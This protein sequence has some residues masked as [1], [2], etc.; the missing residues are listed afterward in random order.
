MFLGIPYAAP[1]VGEGRFA[2]PQRPERPEGIRDALAYGATALQPQ[3]EFTLIPEPLVLGDNCLNFNVFTPVPGHSGL[4]VLVWIHGG[5]FFAGCNA[6]PWYRGERFARDGVVLVSINY[7]LGVEGFLPV[8]D[9]GADRGVLDWLAAL[10]WVQHNIAAFGGNPS[11]PRRQHEWTGG[12]GGDGRAGAETARTAAAGPRHPAHPR[13][14]LSEVPIER[15]L[16][17]RAPPRPDRPGRKPPTFKRSREAD[18]EC[19]RWPPV[20]RPGTSCPAI[21]SRPCVAGVASGRPDAP[22]PRSSTW[23][24][25]SWAG[26]IDDEAADKAFAGDGALC[27]RARGLPGVAARLHRRGHHGADA[28]RPDVPR[29]HR[30]AVRGEGGR[31]RRYLP[32]PV[33]LALAGHGRPVRV[34]APGVEIAL[35]SEPPQGLADRMHR[36]WVG[37]VTD[38]D[39]GWPAFSLDTRPVMV[40][41]DESTV[42]NDPLRLPRSLWGTA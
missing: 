13:H 29:A 24:S 38:A 16:Q 10:E 28:D 3:Q 2:P 8:E 37:F 15:L 1:P 23:C 35:G 27:G 17:T 33:G 22:R 9:G 12:A 4:P 26:D 32:L 30:S 41:D 21:R 5:G 19:C 7:R 31:R 34:G 20:R 25:H 11:A 36:A 39:P 18:G 14:E 42:M 6:S 40:I